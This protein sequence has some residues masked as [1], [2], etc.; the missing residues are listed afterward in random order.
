[1]DHR[2]G[3]RFYSYTQRCRNVT[4]SIFFITKLHSFL[5]SPISTQQK[6]SNFW[7][8][9]TQCSVAWRWSMPSGP[10]PHPLAGS[11]LGLLT[12]LRCL[13]LWVAA[14]VSAAGVPSCPPDVLLEAGHC[15][16]CRSLW[17]SVAITVFRCRL[18]TGLWATWEG[19]TTQ[20]G[21]R[22]HHFCLSHW[23]HSCRGLPRFQVGNIW[24]P[25]A[26]RLVWW[27]GTFTHGS[28]AWS[29]FSFLLRVFNF[30]LEWKNC[31]RL[32]SS[33]LPNLF[34]WP[35]RLWSFLVTLKT[36]QNCFFCKSTMLRLLLHG[37]IYELCSEV[38][39]KW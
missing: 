22:C 17:V 36:K 5:G 27:R 34:S 15:R 26:L 20:E 18:G 23:C 39:A 37:G 14:S 3:L 10:L 7:F 19:R 13:G 16:R 30:P 2:V 31:S 11:V 38:K 28:L 4:F 1:M 9:V 33:I 35:S 8:K 25:S 29:P 21:S 6:Q 12:T 32:L 24:R